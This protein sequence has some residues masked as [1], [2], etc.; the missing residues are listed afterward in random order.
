MLRDTTTFSAVS[1]MTVPEKVSSYLG[2]FLLLSGFGPSESWAA[3]WAPVRD[4]TSRTRGRRNR[5]LES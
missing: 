2:S 3:G 1:S 5:T 4:T